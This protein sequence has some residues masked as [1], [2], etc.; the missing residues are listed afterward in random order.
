MEEFEKYLNEILTITE[1]VEITISTRKII[2]INE[3]I[4]DTLIRINNKEFIPNN[5][6][7]EIEHEIIKLL[8][9]INIKTS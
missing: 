2:Y 9:E 4:I 8:S 1:N 6:Q 5:R 3:L 7:R